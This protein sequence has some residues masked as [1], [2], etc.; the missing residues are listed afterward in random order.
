[1]QMNSEPH[2]H[3]PHLKDG[4][5]HDTNGKV[6]WGPF[7]KNGPLD[8]AAFHHYS[9]KSY[10]EHVKK[11]QRGRVSVI[12]NE[13]ELMNHYYPSIKLF[14]DA[15]EKNSS[16]ELGLAGPDVIF[17]DLAWSLLKKISPGYAVFDELN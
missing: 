16:G 2:G 6:F 13:T 9:T 17:D 1:M 10:A 14:E 11:R 8:V 15:L 7:N 3:F 4:N 5:Q 12:L